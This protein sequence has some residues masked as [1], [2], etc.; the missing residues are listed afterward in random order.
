[1]VD[2]LLGMAVEGVKNLLHS[3]IGHNAMHVAAHKAGHAIEGMF[4]KREDNQTKN[5]GDSCDTPT[6]WERDM[7]QVTKCRNCGKDVSISSR[8]CWNCDAAL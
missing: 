1:M 3:E 2:V 6:S 4:E 8:R 5:T 7:S